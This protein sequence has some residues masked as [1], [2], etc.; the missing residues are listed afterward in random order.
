MKPKLHGAQR[1]GSDGEQKRAFLQALGAN[2]QDFGPAKMRQTETSKGEAF[3][4]GSCWQMNAPQELS[5]REN[6]G[7]VARDKFDHW[8][9][10]RL[11][12]PRPK[13]ANAFQR[14]GEGDHRAC[15]ER[16][17]DISAYRGFIP[18]FERGQER[19]AAIPEKRGG[20]PIRWRFFY[21]LIEF[22]NFASSSNL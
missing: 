19:T 20:R 12:T 13:C 4:Q 9:F 7:M 16:H 5:R 22:D 18:D 6:I 10:A 17:A 2:Q 21:E 11:S 15:G 1:G 8:Y 3:L 14:C